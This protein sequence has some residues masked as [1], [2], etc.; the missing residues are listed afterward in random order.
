MYGYTSE[1]WNGLEQGQFYI[2]STKLETY[3]GY[4]KAIVLGWLYPF[5]NVYILGRLEKF[6]SHERNICIKLHSNANIK[7]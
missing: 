7:I 6:K 2:L 1:A 3:V 4:D 5:R